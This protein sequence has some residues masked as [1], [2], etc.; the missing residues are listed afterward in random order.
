[1]SD[2][3][4][5][6]LGM[7]DG[8][9]HPYSWTA[10]INGTYNAEEMKRSEYPVIPEYLGA[11]PPESLGIPG[12]TVTHI[13]T[14]DPKDA[15]HVAKAALIEN[16]AREPT[17]VISEVDAVIIPTDRGDEHVD[18]ARPFVEAGLPVF[19]DKPLAD[20]EKDLQQFVDWVR[21]GKRILSTSAM[22]YA[23]EFAGYR[24]NRAAALGELRYVSSTTNKSWE[25]YG[26]HALEMVFPILK[27][28]FQS[29]RNTGS[30]DRNIVH[31]KHTSGA[32]CLIAAVKD[33]YGAFGKV[34]L[35]GTKSSAYVEFTDT[36]YAFK[37]QLVAFIEYLK[38]GVLPFP[39]EETVELM[40]V[41]IAGIRSREHGGE[42]VPLTDIHIV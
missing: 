42:E 10:I 34:F 21:E 39:F 27:P 3:R 37:A 7:V 17:D 4:L 25:R 20:N 1:M 9:G 36:F 22:R 26:I 11:E 23:Q 35:A 6:M 13:W 16:V 2:I 41:I 19:I 40:K 32:D 8:N 31:L 38:T 33:M 5:A 24:R 29:V 18:R 12:A 30:L 28:G 15:E 14:D